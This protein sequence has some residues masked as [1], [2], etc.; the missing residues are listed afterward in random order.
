MASASRSPNIRVDVA[1]VVG[2]A[3]QS[4]LLTLAIIYPLFT[5]LAP[6]PVVS[7][8]MSLSQSAAAPPSCAL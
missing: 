4:L 6:A 5:W 7:K 8:L 1:A 3:L 2:N